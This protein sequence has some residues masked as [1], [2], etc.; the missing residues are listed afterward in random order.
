[1]SDLRH[2]SRYRARGVSAGKADV[3]AAIAK[4]DA[5]LFPGAFCKLMPDLLG[6]DARYCL[7]MHADGA[8]TKSSLAYLAWRE[9]FPPELWA[10]L[11]QDSLVMNLDDCACVGSLGPYLVSNTIGRNALRIPGEV[12]GMIVDGYQQVCDQLGRYGISCHLAGG[13]TADLGDL[14]R[15][16]DITSTVIARMPRERV[17]DAGRMVP[18]DAIVGF[19]STG[20]AAWES[21][22][23]SGIGANGLTSA[24]HE[25]LGHDYRARFAETYAPEIDPALVYCGPFKLNDALPGD[26]TFTIASALLSPTRTYL[27]LIKRLL[28]SVP[29]MDLHGLIHCSGG[30][31]SK[32]VKF[33]GRGRR[34]GLRFVKDALFAIPPLF[35]AL[36][37]ATGMA[38]PEMYAVYNMGHRLEAVVPLNLVDLCLSAARDCHIDA[39]VVGRIE[40]RDVPGNEVVVK[41]RH[42]EFKYW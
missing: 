34:N 40:S 41:T 29:L 3:H 20:Q 12:I 2:D 42:G 18:G 31:Q 16:I 10:G 26:P 27:P 22:P 37:Q 15:T 30:G 7:V 14:V 32:I 5:G 21:A 28:D 33:G 24:R 35:E 17:I 38:W 4:Q 36:Q 8:G 11:A 39:Q 9:G 23:N 6:G 1:M 19:S 13:E 25:L